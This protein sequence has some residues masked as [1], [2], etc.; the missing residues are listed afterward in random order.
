MR[1]IQTLVP[2]SFCPLTNP[3]PYQREQ[4][5]RRR[6][7]SRVARSGSVEVISKVE[8]TAVRR[9]LHRMV[10]PKTRWFE[11]WYHQYDCSVSLSESR[12]RPAAARALDSS[13]LSPRR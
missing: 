8:R 5:E 3:Q 11:G 6:A 2:D 10:R 12:L 1:A 13:Q 7:R 9:S 4:D